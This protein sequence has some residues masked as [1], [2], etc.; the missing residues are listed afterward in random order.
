MAK[1]SRTSTALIRTSS[2]LPVKP[3]KPLAHRS[4]RVHQDRPRSTKNP[5]TIIPPPQSARIVQRYICG[6]SLRKIARAEHRD[7]G[8]VAKIVRGPEVAEYIEVLR[9][10]FY[11]ALEIAMDTL[12]NELQNPSSKTRGGLACEMLKSSGVVP[13]RNQTMDLESQPSSQIRKAKRRR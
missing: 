7:R 8:T 1:R 10:K 12:L 13:N 11:G 2:P 6:E 9:G 5:R 3:A 4:P